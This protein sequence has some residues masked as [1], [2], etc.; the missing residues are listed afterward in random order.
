MAPSVS[1]HAT[2]MHSLL[3]LKL[4]VQRILDQLKAVSAKVD[5]SVESIEIASFL[6]VVLAI[7]LVKFYYYLLKK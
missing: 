5:M 1:S 7:V 2:T 3:K 6:I 4:V